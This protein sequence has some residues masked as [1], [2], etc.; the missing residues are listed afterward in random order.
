MKKQVV[1][2]GDYGF[3]QRIDVPDTSD[4]RV[5]DSERI[6]VSAEGHYLDKD[7]IYAIYEISSENLLKP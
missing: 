6:Y 7:K 4:F 1:I 3:T 5:G 2:N